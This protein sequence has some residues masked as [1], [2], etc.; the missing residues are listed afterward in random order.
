[1]KRILLEDYIDDIG[2]DKLED[3]VEGVTPEEIR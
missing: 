3:E 1:M 2:L